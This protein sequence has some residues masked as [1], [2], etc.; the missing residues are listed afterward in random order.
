M[1]ESPHNEQRNGSADAEESR[2]TGLLA[3][4][5]SVAAAAIGVQSRK[6]RERDF[7]HGKA[8]HFVV[9]GIIGTLIFLLA[10]YAF[11]RVMLASA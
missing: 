3:I 2:G 4:A 1:S 8:W 7:Q 9:G 5:H 10:V 11:V 6:N